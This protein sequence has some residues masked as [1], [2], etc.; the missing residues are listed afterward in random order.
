M[1]KY[2][3]MFSLVYDQNFFNIFSSSNFLERLLKKC[4]ILLF[5]KVIRTKYRSYMCVDIFCNIF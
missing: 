4:F 3:N 2:T 1:S 5:L